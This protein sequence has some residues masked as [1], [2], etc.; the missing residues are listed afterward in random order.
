[1]ADAIW[2]Q[3]EGRSAAFF[4]RVGRRPALSVVSGVDEAAAAYARQI[5]RQFVRHGL[6]VVCA[7]PAATEYLSEVSRL[8][9]DTRIDGTLLLT[10][11]PA[12]VDREQAL[13]VLEPAKDVDGLHPTSLGRLAQR[14]AGFAPA[15]AEGGLRLLEYYSVPL[16]GARVVVVGRGPV[17][18]MPLA[19][20]LIDADATVTV[21]HSRT[22]DLAAVSRSADVLC[23]AAGRPGLIRPAHIK[24]GAVVV[25]FGTNVGS[26]GSLIG[27]VQTSEVMAI[28]GAITP[29]PGGTGPTTV[30]VLAEHT[31]RAAESAA[32]PND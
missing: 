27:D 22:L 18:G 5:E 9:S 32:A 6:Q 17:V 25:D 29:V 4:Q 20:L 15:T 8:M 31:L 24:P 28:A 10:P 2:R 21:C 26:D 30:A 3:V 1:V 23:V 16:R 19:L 14:Q 12:E 7:T 11:L 13:A